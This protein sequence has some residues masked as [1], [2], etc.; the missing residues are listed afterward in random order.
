[1]KLVLLIRKL[2]DLSWSEVEFNTSLGDK[3]LQSVLRVNFLSEKLIP[4]RSLQNETYKKGT[5]WNNIISCLCS[6]WFVLWFLVLSWIESHFRMLAVFSL[7]LIFS[8]ILICGG[9]SNTTTKVKQFPW[10]RI[11]NFNLLTS[12]IFSTYYVFTKEIIWHWQQKNPLY[13]VTGRWKETSHICLFC[14]VFLFSSLRFMCCH[15]MGEQQ[16][17]GKNVICDSC[18]L[19]IWSCF[20]SFMLWCLWVLLKL[21]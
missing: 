8:W 1:M 14:F 18:I 10:F 13:S 11:K 12:L 5:D 20:S 19:M 21:L 9:K 7:P 4:L 16:K 17:H 15:N 3:V 6:A 2:C